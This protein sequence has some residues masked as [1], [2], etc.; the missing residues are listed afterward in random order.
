MDF[1]SLVHYELYG[2]IIKLYKKDS[3]GKC[4]T[5]IFDMIKNNHTTLRCD[6]IFFKLIIAP[7][8]WGVIV[9]V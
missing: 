1:K 9:E 7:L 2:Q 4:S 6:I 5:Y 8:M 3:S